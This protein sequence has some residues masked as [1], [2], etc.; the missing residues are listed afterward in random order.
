MG[1]MRLRIVILHSGGRGRKIALNLRP[2]FS[3]KQENKN[4]K[5]SQ[6]NAT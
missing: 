2:A 5:T 6:K 3:Q 1:V 4:K